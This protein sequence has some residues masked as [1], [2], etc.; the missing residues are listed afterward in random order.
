M[1]QAKYYLKKFVIQTLLYHGPVWN[2]IFWP[3]FLAISFLT[4]LT[5]GIQKNLLNFITYTVQNI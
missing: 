3:S 1:I 2:R 4:T 5:T